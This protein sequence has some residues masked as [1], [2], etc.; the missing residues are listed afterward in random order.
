[1]LRFW[2]LLF[3]VSLTVSV[4]EKK[5]KCLEGGNHKHRPTE[6]NNLKECTLYT[7]SSCCHADIT[8]ELA[9]SPVIKVNTT[10]WNRCGNLSKSCEDY[11][12]KLECFY[13]C[14][15]HAAFWAHHQYEAA[16]DSVPMC[17]KFC[18]N[19]YDACKN[20]LT[21]V[22]NSL[23]DWEIDERG[24]N[25]CK[26]ECISYSQ[27]YA[28]GTDICETMWGISLKVS[29]SNCLCLQMNEMDDKVIKIMKERSSNSS[30]TTSTTKDDEELCHLQTDK[31]KQVEEIREDATGI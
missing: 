8:E 29:D 9:H 28:N 22:K 4:S 13:R 12:K 6:E 30:T 17:Q 2:M 27:M 24:E 19:W 21:C 18:D 20:D 5:Q 16:I 15:P 7:K 23:T 3:F 31:I 25:H 26:N 1:M 14:S 11:M 10:Y